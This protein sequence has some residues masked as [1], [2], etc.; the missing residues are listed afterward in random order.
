MRTRGLFLI[1]ISLIV[2]SINDLAQ[3][4]NSSNKP[5]SFNDWLNQQLV[6]KLN[7][8]SNTKQTETPSQSDASTSLVDQSSATDLISAALNLAGLANSSSDSTNPKSASVTASAYSVYALFKGQDP[9]NAKFYDDHAAWRRLSFTLGSDSGTTTTSGSSPQRATIAGMKVLIVDRRDLSMNPRKPSN[10]VEGIF[11]ALQA[12]TTAFGQ[13]STDVALYLIRNSKVR[14]AIV[15][16]GWEPFLQQELQIAKPDGKAKIQMLIDGLHDDKTGAFDHLFLGDPSQW[17]REERKYF[18]EEFQNKHFLSDF[19][20]LVK[21][22]GD[23]GSHDLDEIISR[24]LDVFPS[25]D[26]AIQIKIEQIRRAPQFSLALTSTTRPGRGANEYVA[27]TIFDY[28]VANR[29]NLTLNNTFNYKDTKVL[30][31]ISRGSKFVGD[32]QFQLT[33]EKRFSGRGPIT[34]DVG[35]EGDWMTK[36]RPTYKGQV[37]IKIPITDGIDLP[38]SVTFANRT[39]LI[40]ERDVVGKF[41]FTFDTAKLFSFL[42]K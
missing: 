16:P 27:E 14:A 21:L 23:A 17:T 6:A 38:V 32:L 20:D 22:I 42:S 36:A 26:R 2:F 19:S 4:Q 30:G 11:G 41:G 15:E 29:I 12:A 24:R 13:I 34:F 3:G 37:K 10:S 31:G 18:A 39:D 35:T 33:P 5:E 9:L 1:V 40:N 28:G 7:Q 8:R 25:L